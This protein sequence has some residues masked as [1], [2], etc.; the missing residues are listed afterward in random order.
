MESGAWIRRHTVPAGVHQVANQSH[1]SHWCYA[2]RFSQ[3]TRPR[4]RAHVNRREHRLVGASCLDANAITDFLDLDKHGTFFRRIV[5]PVEREH[6]AG[7]ESPKNHAVSAIDTRP[8]LRQMKHRAPRLAHWTVVRMGRQDAAQVFPP[9]LAREP[10]CSETS[11]RCRI[12]SVATPRSTGLRGKLTP[13]MTRH[14][15]L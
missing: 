6:Q 14:I 12:S 2:F 3:P 11:P 15:R 7:V 1:G 5:G 4:S 8:C 9:P 10:R 13:A